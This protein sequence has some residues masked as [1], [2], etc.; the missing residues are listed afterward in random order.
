MSITF[1]YPSQS[2]AQ[3][4]GERRISKSRGFSA[5]GSFVPLPQPPLR[6]LALV[7]FF[8]RAKHQKSCFSDFLC[9]PTETL[10]TQ[11]IYTL[12]Y[13]CVENE[14]PKTKTED[15]R[16]TGLKRRSTGLKRRPTGLN[17]TQFHLEF[18]LVSQ[19]EVPVMNTSEATK[20]VE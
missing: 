18:L 10:A 3:F 6:F 2:R 16:P 8:A 14:D 12:V 11:A 5:S 13:G 15:L 4:A 1:D 19:H 17:S 7:P 20:K 9:Y